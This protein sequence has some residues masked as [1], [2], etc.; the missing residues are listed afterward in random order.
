MGERT[1]QVGNIVPTITRETGGRYEY[2]KD[3][4]YRCT[5]ARMQHQFNCYFDQLPP[6]ICPVCNAP[7]R[8]FIAKGE[9]VES[10]V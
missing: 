7:M 1:N 10:D 2:R 5:N 6:E 8:P 9:I 4:F 3:V